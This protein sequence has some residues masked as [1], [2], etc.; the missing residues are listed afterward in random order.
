MLKT[1]TRP[2]VTHGFVIDF[3]ENHMVL[4]GISTTG[5]DGV[6][7][8]LGIS[9]PEIRQFFAET[10][11]LIA[12]VIE[13]FGARLSV[14][15][16]FGCGADLGFSSLLRAHLETLAK[17]EDFYRRLLLE[18]DLVPTSARG[19]I[20]SIHAILSE[21]LYAAARKEIA[22]G[23]IKSMERPMLFNL[24]LGWVHHFVLNRDLFSDETP[25]LQHRKND[26]I[27]HFT[28]LLE[29]GP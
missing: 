7:A 28:R 25:V 9:G 6:A 19:L 26:L 11:D 17:F 22:A 5:L 8:A 20:F 23:R 24:W 15:L 10:E 18:S 2:P 27:A 21:R 29:V 14:E 12:A 1:G 4:H 13:N 3:A 16:E